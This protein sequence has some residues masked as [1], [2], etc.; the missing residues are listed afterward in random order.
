MS[1]RVT[2]PGTAL[3]I[4][5][6]EFGVQSH[7]GGNKARLYT[8]GN[9]PAARDAVSESLQATY[10]RQALQL[11]ACQPSVV[12]LLFFHVSDENDLRAWQSGLFYADD[13]PKTSLAAV[14]QLADAAQAGTLT[15]AKAKPKP[16]P[17]RHRPRR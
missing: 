14:K 3:P 9:A 15:C 10:Y 7:I 6:D 11:A 5:Y 4:L 16:K 13:T 1:C 17:K 2:A 8:H 12:G